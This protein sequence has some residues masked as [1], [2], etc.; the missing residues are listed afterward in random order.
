MPISE[1]YN[2]SFRTISP[3]GLNFRYQ[4]ES[5][6]QS[7]LLRYQSQNIYGLDGALT[8]GL[9]TFL[10]LSWNN[11]TGAF[12]SYSKLFVVNGT[13]APRQFSH[14]HYDPDLLGLFIPPT[15]SS[16]SAPQTKETNGVKIG[17]A[18]GVV[19]V[20]GAASAIAAIYW[21]HN[22]LLF[23]KAHKLV[24]ANANTAPKT[25]STT[26]TESPPAATH[27]PASDTVATTTTWSLA[28]KPDV[29]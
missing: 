1:P 23:A 12:S 7:I 3:N 27:S 20:A 2:V 18:V 10:N 22:K 19:A 15:N 14:F 29:I 25:H 4:A 17:A 16:A 28:A 6:D 5:L 11:Q 24:R 8:Y 21:Y 13:M 26:P 9:P